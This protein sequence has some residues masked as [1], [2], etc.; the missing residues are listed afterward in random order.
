MSRLLVEKE[1][2]TR[3][4][5]SQAIMKKVALSLKWT[6]VC[7][8]A[9]RW[10]RLLIGSLSGL[11]YAIQSVSGEDWY[12]LRSKNW[13]FCYFQNVL[14]MM[15]LQLRCL[16]TVSIIFQHFILSQ[17]N[18]T[19]LSQPE[20]LNAHAH[21]A[22]I[23]G[24]KRSIRITDHFTCTLANVVY[25]I[26]C[27]LCKKLYIGETG[28]RLRDRF[29]ENLRDI[30]KDDKNASKPVHNHSNQHMAVCGLSLHQWSTES[31]KL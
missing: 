28:R 30:E 22:K 4:A 27:T 8:T 12:G 11:C 16:E 9:S 21:D 31:R 19:I 14:S 1:S 17:V 24:P 15:L 23:S 13:A 25:C 2:T 5:C 29:R 18:I 10:R 26:T 3:R 20:L 7:D 6:L